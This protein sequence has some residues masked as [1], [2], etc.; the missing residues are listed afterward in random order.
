MR[1]DKESRIDAPK[2]LPMAGGG[3]LRA[4]PWLTV[5]PREGISPKGVTDVI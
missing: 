2:G 3:R 5:S 1:R 4:L